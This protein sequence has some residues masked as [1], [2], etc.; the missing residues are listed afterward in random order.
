[1]SIILEKVLFVLCAFA[2]VFCVRLLLVAFFCSVDIVAGN[3]S[4]LSG[5]L[6]ETGEFTARL[7]RYCEDKGERNVMVEF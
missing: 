6:N 5:I 2:V 7:P 3:C 1:M 4:I